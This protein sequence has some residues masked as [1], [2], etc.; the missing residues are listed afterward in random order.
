MMLLRVRRDLPWVRRARFAAVLFGCG[1]VAVLVSAFAASA[2]SQTMH[3]AAAIQKPG[4]AKP[5]YWQSEAPARA[6]SRAMSVE[7]RER[8]GDQIRGRVT[9]VG[10]SLL[11]QGS[12]EGT[13][14]GMF[15]S[16]V[17]RDERGE[18]AARFV[19]RVNANGTMSGTYTD[20]TG[21]TGSWQWPER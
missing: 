2:V 8:V 18:V 7:I 12:I 3:E 5:G 4:P 11:E 13:V 6:A 16:G 21:E 15:V 14:R 17:V 20:R 1:A 9:V 10:S 19:G